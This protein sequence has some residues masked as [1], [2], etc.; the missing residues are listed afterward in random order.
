MKQFFPLLLASAFVSIASAQT[1]KDVVEGNVIRNQPFH[2]SVIG[3]GVDP[4]SITLSPLNMAVGY[5]L[6]A[7]AMFNNKFRIDGEYHGSYV[8]VYSSKD[9]VDYQ[10]LNGQPEG[11]ETKFRTWELG[12]RYFLTNKSKNVEEKVVLRNA[13]RVTYYTTVNANQVRLLGA[14]AGVGGYK[15]YTTANTDDFFIGEDSQGHEVKIPGS[16]NLGINVGATMVHLGISYTSISDV[17]LEVTKMP[18]INM[19][20]PRIKKE[21]S[22]NEYYADI[23]FAPSVKYDNVIV[24]WDTAGFDGF[25]NPLATSPPVKYDLNNKTPKSKIGF[26]VGWNY[27]PYK[28]ATFKTGLEAG[29]LPGGGWGPIANAYLRFKI[30]FGYTSFTD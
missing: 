24:N 26:R 1:S 28:K 12:L 6:N 8:N 13:A 5:T 29:I 23:L 22:D 3:G 30:I 9:I 16:E 27:T 17:I 14:R 10:G 15:T 4:L 21:Q 7:H 2:K 20:K 18:G 11:G 25:G 19:T